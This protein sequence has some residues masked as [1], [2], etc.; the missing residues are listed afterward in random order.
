[1][2]LLQAYLQNSQTQNVLNRK[3]GE[4][5]FS[6]I[7]LVVVVAVLAILSA[8]AIPNFLSINDE[9]RVAGV[10]NTLATLVKEC[11]VK[12][13]SSGSTAF[14][15]PSLGSSNYAFG[16]SG[17]GASAGVCNTA[18]IYTAAPVSGTNL[19]TF[20]VTQGGAKT[21]TNASSGANAA[22]GCTGA[23]VGSPGSW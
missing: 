20:I 23:A 17:T 18:N 1:M 13:S 7:E 21:C 11:A 9:A 2:S 3:P 15:T 22:L 5:G 6:L 8:I 12:L 19:P 10:K 14:N 16:L 4:K